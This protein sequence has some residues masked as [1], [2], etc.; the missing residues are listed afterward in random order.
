MCATRDICHRVEY[1]F[2]ALGF[3]PLLFKLALLLARLALVGLF[4][5]LSL[6]QLCLLC[7]SALRQRRAAVGA[8]VVLFGVNDRV[9]V[10][11][12]YLHLFSSILALW[13][14]VAYCA[15]V[16]KSR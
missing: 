8:G 11:A 5:L 7:L 15:A 2:A 12:G 6:A 9:A 14:I 4:F 1:H 13:V 16:F 10:F 3:Y